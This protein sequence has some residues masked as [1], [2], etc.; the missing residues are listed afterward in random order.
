MY[1]VKDKEILKKMKDKYIQ[2]D[3]ADKDR[4]NELCEKIK[5][6]G[7]RIKTSDKR[8]TRTYRKH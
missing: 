7:S 8:K 2:A 1:N 6:T 4:Y 3:K 5:K